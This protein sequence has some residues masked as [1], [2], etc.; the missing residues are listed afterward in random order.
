MKKLQI[1]WRYSNIDLLLNAIENANG[2][3]EDLMSEIREQNRTLCE[4]ISGSSKDAFA[5][6]YLILHSHMIKLRK[7]L[8]DLIKKGREAAKKTKDHDDKLANVIKRKR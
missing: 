1:V 2:S 5:Q 4:S 7:D 6:N 3:I 8:E